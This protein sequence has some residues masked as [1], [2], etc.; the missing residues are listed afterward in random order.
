[1]GRFNSKVAS[2]L[3][4]LASDL[5]KYIKAR[6]PSTR[7]FAMQKY[8]YQGLAGGLVGGG[9]MCLDDVEWTFPLTN[10]DD[11]T[12]RKFVTKRRVDNGTV[13]FPVPLHIL[14]K[15]HE[16][17][18]G[19]EETCPSAELSNGGVDTRNCIPGEGT[20][21]LF[22]PLLVGSIRTLPFP[23]NEADEKPNIEFRWSDR[24]SYNELIK[25]YSADKIARVR[26]LVNQNGCLTEDFG[27]SLMFVRLPSD[28]ST[29]QRSLGMPLLSAILKWAKR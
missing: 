2:L 12:P 19:T 14:Q 21:L 24:N 8:S 5:T 23:L 10:V 13:A 28:R 11:A 29:P 6:S 22:C 7:Q 16:T 25:L 3:P 15:K 4:T 27:N 20:S 9:G 18:S 26:L 17:C 1:V